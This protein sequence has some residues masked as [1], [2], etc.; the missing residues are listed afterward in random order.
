MRIGARL[1]AN[2]WSELEPM[3]A[4]IANRQPC[5]VLGWKTPYEYLQEKLGI[6]EARRRPAGVHLRVPGC[7]AYP[8]DKDVPRA[9]KNTPRAHIGYLVGY[10]ST[11]I[12]RIW[13]PSRNTVLSTRDVI[14]DESRMYDPDEP[15]LVNA[16]P[17]Y[18]CE[19]I[20]VR[21]MTT[22]TEELTQ[23]MPE[24]DI[25]ATA[26]ASANDGA[27]QEQNEQ[28]S[29]SDETSAI[30][31][32]EYDSSDS[33]RFLPTPRA[34][35]PIDLSSPTATECATTPSSTTM[36]SATATGSDPGPG[37]SRPR[38]TAN[39]APRAAEI[40]GNHDPNLIIEGSRTRQP[41][42]RRQAYL[43]ALQRPED[44]P[45]YYAAFN[46]ALDRSDESRPR[47]HRDQLPPP[48]KSWRDL[49][50]HPHMAGFLAAAQT[51]FTALQNKGMF[52]SMHLTPQIASQTVLPLLWVFT[53]KFDTDGYLLK[54]K[55]RICVRGDLQPQSNQIGRAHV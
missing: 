17:E 23:T 5:E 7:R 10:D 14:F 27:D 30:Q 49:K 2:A 40:S 51:E 6:P 52:E 29:T 28:D 53:Y 36:S 12:Y 35:P 25:N 24:S 34:T 32:P 26:I 4:H 9:A 8:R 1:P 39:T 31:T 13:V 45:G 48:P 46:A 55:A 18:I 20:H 41:S 47:L 16:N 3:A 43:V 21:P 15:D 44:A 19:V 33:G 22:L 37:P 54:Y 38:H 42:T 50:Q 11:N